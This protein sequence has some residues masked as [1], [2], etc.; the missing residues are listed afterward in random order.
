METIQNPKSKIQNLKIAVV[1]VGSLGQHHARNYA[2]IA[3]ENKIE[4]VAVC[5]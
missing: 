2:D 1:G 4:L 5:G 3:L